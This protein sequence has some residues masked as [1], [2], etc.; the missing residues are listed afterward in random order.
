MKTKYPVTALLAFGDNGQK[1]TSL[2]EINTCEELYIMGMLAAVKKN[3]IGAVVISVFDWYR[4]HYQCTYGLRC[5]ADLSLQHLTT[6]PKRRSFSKSLILLSW[7][8]DV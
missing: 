3:R 6:Q 1:L 4:T 8:L 5:S 7:S 2:L